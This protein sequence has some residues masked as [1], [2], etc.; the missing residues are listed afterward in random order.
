MSNLTIMDIA[1][2]AELPIIIHSRDAAKDTYDVMKSNKADEIGGVIHCF[3]Y[4][5][6][7]AKQFD[8]IDN[9]L[10]YINNNNIRFDANLVLAE[11]SDFLFRYMQCVD[12]AVEIRTELYHYSRDNESTVRSYNA[13]TTKNYVNSINN[14]LKYVKNDGEEIR[15]AY[16]Q[17]IL[18]HLILILV[19]DTYNV[20]NPATGKQKKHNMKKLLK[21]ILALVFAACCFM[22]AAKCLKAGGFTGAIADFP[23]A[24]HRA[25]KGQMQTTTD[26]LNGEQTEYDESV[27]TGEYHYYYEKLSDDDKLIYRQIYAMMQKR[28]DGISLNTTDTDNV[29]RIQ[30]F[31]LLD[32]PQF[33]YIEKSQYTVRNSIIFSPVYNMSEADIDNAISTISGYVSACMAG[34]DEGASDYDKAVHFYEYVIEHAEYEENSPHNQDMYSAVLGRTVCQGYAMMFKYLCDRAG[35]SS[36]IVTGTTSDANHAWN[37]VYLDGAWCA[38]DCTYGDGDYLGKGISYSWFGVPL[39]VV[40]LT[41]TLDNEDML[42]QEATVEDD[43]YYR[44]GLYFT[45]YDLKTLQGMTTSSNYITFKFS[46]RETYDTACHSLFEKGDYKYLI[47]TARGGTITYMQ[48]PNSLAVFIHIELGC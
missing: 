3:S 22:F 13:D 48:E 30:Q 7:M 40:K 12:S 9:W 41:R 24:I 23:T 16:N 15:K 14:T 44:N 32:N 29:S 25:V 31:V 39:D 19:H 47:P 38:V 21:T 35:I 1:R 11:D 27:F 26:Y 37:M 46:D 4:T 8:T 43:Y 17:Y 28:M 42:P 5:K 10:E 20:N 34:I 36:L 2:E 45:S 6:E 18:I 33:F